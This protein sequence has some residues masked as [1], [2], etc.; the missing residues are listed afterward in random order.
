MLD[1]CV[2]WKR[3]LKLLTQD[4]C[5]QKFVYSLNQTVKLVRLRLSLKYFSS[6]E[7]LYSPRNHVANHS[8]E[9]IVDSVNGHWGVE[10]ELIAPHKLMMASLLHMFSVYTHKVVRFN[11]GQ[12]YFVLALDSPACKQ[13]VTV[14][15]SC[16]AWKH[17]RVSNC[18]FRDVENFADEATYSLLVIFL[19]HVLLCLIIQP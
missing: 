13:K 14:P 12:I 11:T 8:R 5:F 15:A 6:V 16:V 10:Q 9:L 2:L 18:F 17:V 7:W 3:Y 1:K 19:F 4:F